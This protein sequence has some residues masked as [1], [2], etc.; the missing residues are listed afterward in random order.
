MR[1]RNRLDKL[2]AA[3]TAPV[4]IEVWLFDLDGTTTTGPDGRRYTAQEAERLQAD[5]ELVIDLRR[6]AVRLKRRLENLEGYTR[7]GMVYGQQ[8]PADLAPLMLRAPA[9]LSR[10]ESRKLHSYRYDHDAGYRVMSDK[11]VPI[12]ALEIMLEALVRRDFITSEGYEDVPDVVARELLGRDD[13]SPEARERVQRH[14]DGGGY[15]P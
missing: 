8:Y 15:E 10:D 2:K 9:H 1:L 14:L 5:A 4:S 13:T 7:S 12:R 6:P 3:H 11:P